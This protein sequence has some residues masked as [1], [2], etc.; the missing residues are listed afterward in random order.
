MLSNALNH[1]EKSISVSIEKEKRLFEQIWLI[2]GLLL[3]GALFQVLL[4]R[5]Y[6]QR[7]IRELEE[8]HRK[9]AE[10][11]RIGDELNMAKGIQTAMLMTV[12]K[13]LIRTQLMMG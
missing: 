6:W 5:H 12:S 2:G 4:S 9:E 1:D 13:T 8:E 10:R 7:K 11:Q 3:G